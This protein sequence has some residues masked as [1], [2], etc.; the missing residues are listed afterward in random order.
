MVKVAQA[1]FAVASF[2]GL[3]DIHKCLG[4]LQMAPY[5]LNKQTAG[6]YSPHNWLMSFALDLAALCDMWRWNST[7]GCHL[8]VYSEDIA[9]SRHFMATHLPS[10]CNPIGG[11]VVLATPVKNCL[12]YWAIQLAIH[13]IVGE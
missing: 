2:W 11:V 1:A 13:S 9:F 10:P 12:K 3:S 6:F 8:A 7:N 4:H 5:P